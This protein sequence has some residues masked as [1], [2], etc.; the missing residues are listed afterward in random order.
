MH[1]NVNGREGKESGNEHLKGSTAVPRNLSGNLTR[2]LCSTG[3]C[4]KV[5]A[6]VV[7][8]KN[9]SK[10]RERKTQ[11]NV[12]SRHRQNG[13]KGQRTRR[14][15]RKGHRV[16][17][18]EYCDTGTGEQG[19]SKKDTSHPLLSIHLTVQLDRGVSTNHAKEAVKHNHS[20]EN[21]AALCRR[22]ETRQ[23][24]AQVEQGDTDEL[25]SSSDSCT[26]KG[27]VLREPKDVSVNQLPTRL[28]EMNRR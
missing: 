1:L 5:G 15:M 10:D 20:S 19:R 4:I 17:P 3:W 9:S 6:G 22:N 25:V 13:R 2:H 28:R 11:E 18:H 12:K 24:Q 7:L 8:G 23:S 21:R 16:H 26:E 14:T 27:R